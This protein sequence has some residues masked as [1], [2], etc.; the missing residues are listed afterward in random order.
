MSTYT[1]AQEIAGPDAATFMAALRTVMDQ[2]GITQADLARAAGV[3]P[4]LIGRWIRGTK[5]PSEWT[6]LKL[7][8]ALQRA[9]YGS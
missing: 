3:D 7:D 5:D 8:D 6:R 1:D 9:I 2:N 4:A